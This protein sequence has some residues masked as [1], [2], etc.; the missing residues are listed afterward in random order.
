MLVKML[1]KSKIGNNREEQDYRTTKACVPLGITSLSST[2]LLKGKKM[3][4]IAQRP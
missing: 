4:T 1:S 3:S 2:R